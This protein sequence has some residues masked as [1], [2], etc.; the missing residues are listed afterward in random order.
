MN[1]HAFNEWTIET[2]MV[3]V[4]N[5][6]ASI[7]GR[8]HNRTWLGNLIHSSTVLDLDVAYLVLDPHMLGGTWRRHQVLGK[9]PK[10]M[11]DDQ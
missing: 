3:E 2:L 1:G 9:M 4:W 11:I 6:S 10:G 5:K 7:V 8:V